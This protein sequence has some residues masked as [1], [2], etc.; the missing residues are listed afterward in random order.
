[1][2]AFHD[3]SVE[4]KIKAEAKNVTNEEMLAAINECSFLVFPEGTKVMLSDLTPKDREDIKY[5]IAANRLGEC[6][7]HGPLAIDSVQNHRIWSRAAKRTEKR[8]SKSHI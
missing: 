7:M 2:L 1:M 4:A 8:K 6:I 3:Q 5:E